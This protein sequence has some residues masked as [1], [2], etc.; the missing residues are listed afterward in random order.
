M[1][2]SGGIDLSVGS[3]MGLSAVVLGMLW[4]DAGLP[5]AAAAAL[6]LARRRRR[7]GASTGC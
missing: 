7:G 2:V 4:R 6:T 5:I 1:I 3:L